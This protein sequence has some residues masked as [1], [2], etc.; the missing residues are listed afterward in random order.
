MREE[1]IETRMAQLLRDL[2]RERGLTLQGFEE[3]SGGLIKAVVLGS[4]ERGTRAI[5][6][7]RLQQL[8]DI[9]Q[10]PVEYFLNPSGSTDIDSAERLIFDLKR[11]RELDGNDGEH[12]GLRRYLSSI[13]R[14]RRDWN[15]QVL[16]LRVSDG[17]ILTLIENC[18]FEE[19]ESRLT[20][21]RLLIRASEKSNP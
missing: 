10:V 12:L 20:T 16:S 18:N 7:A 9:Y 21:K 1:D 14:K 6:L 5:S 13:V 4:Y 11:V 15:G 2:R 17:E 8:A 19:L 3:L